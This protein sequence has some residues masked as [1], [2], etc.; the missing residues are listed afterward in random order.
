MSRLRS[1]V[2]TD[3]GLIRPSGCGPELSRLISVLLCKF[4]VLAADEWFASCGWAS[5]LLLSETLNSGLIPSPLHCGDRWGGVPDVLR[6]FLTAL[7]IFLSS[8]T[9]V[10]L[11]LPVGHLLLGTP[12]G[13][14]LV[15]IL[16]VA[17]LAMF[18][19]PTALM[20]SPCVRFKRL[21]LFPTQLSAL[22]V[23]AETQSCRLVTQNF[24]RFDQST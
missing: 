10:F 1:L 7:I 8:S 23:G 17:V 5:T 9:H 18:I 16:Q 2:E 11:G 24:L 13:S 15:R 19:R 6:L 22:H 3:L 20:D 4:L 14:F 21:C 12:V